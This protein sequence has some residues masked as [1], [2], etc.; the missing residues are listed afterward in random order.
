MCEKS[1]VSKM[2]ISSEFACRKQLKH[3]FFPHKRPTYDSQLIG[4]TL[5]E[6]LSQLLIAARASLYSAN[7]LPQPLPL[8]AI[9]SCS[10]RGSYRTQLSSACINPVFVNSV[11]AYDNEIPKHEFKT[12][13]RFE[14]NTTCQC[15]FS[16][17]SLVSQSH[18]LLRVR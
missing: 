16:S 15:S 8:S 1:I 17:L 18:K 3:T 6:Q 10:L 2:T 11:A 12:S 4:I 14:P 5:A 9:D 7:C 13:G